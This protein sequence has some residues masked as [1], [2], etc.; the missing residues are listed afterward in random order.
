LRVGEGRG[1]RGFDAGEEFEAGFAIGE[2]KRF[3][4]F[5]VGDDAGV[6]VGLE[7][8]LL[9]RILKDRIEFRDLV[10]QVLSLD[11][12]GALVASLL[13]PIVL[14]PHLGLM[15]SAFLFGMA[16]VAVA[17][18]STFI[19]KG[20]LPRPGPLRLQCVAVLGLLVAGFVSSENLTQIAESN[21]YADEIILARSTPY[22]RIVLTRWHD[23]V[24]LYLNGHLQFSSKDEHRY[25][26][27]LVHP[28]AAAVA[29]PVRRALVLGGGDGMALREVLRYPSLEEVTLVDL[30]PVMTGLFTTDPLLRPL[31][32]D[33]YHDP[34]VKVVNGDAMRWL[35]EQAEGAWDLIVIDFPDPRSF[36]LGKLYTVEFYR[37]VRRHLSVSGACVV[38]STSPYMAPRAFWCIERSI[39]DAEL[40]TYPYHAYVPS[41]GEWGYVLAL[42][43]KRP[44]PA[45]VVDGIT[46][47][48]FVDDATLR[49]LFV[50]PADMRCPPDV[51]LNRLS[52]QILVKYHE[53]W[54]S[55]E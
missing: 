46:G 28:A 54:L 37:L 3:E 35:E 11:Y 14:V 49:S 33:S 36:S 18:W 39:A 15:R 52:D 5:A 22:Q 24:R 48:R 51:R 38:Q 7:I 45:K 16:N 27:A 40:E 26:E 32:A 31:N 34:R 50:F 43:T 47:L 53:D 19:F 55:A 4:F 42:P 17:L 1:D 12:V 13:F 41:F 30:D 9:L 44:P 21:L 10:A 8:P 6:F 20:L 2:E 23:D 25:H 29:G